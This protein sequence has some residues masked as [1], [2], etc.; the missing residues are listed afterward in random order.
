MLTL[1]RQLLRSK[2]F[3]GLIFG[4]V[5][6]GMAVW[7]IEDIFTGGTGAQVIKS[8]ERGITLAELN[9]AFEDNLQTE[10]LETGA[11]LTRKQGLDQGN[12]SE[13]IGQQSSSI[14][15]LGYA[16]EMRAD[17]SDAAVL[18]EIVSIPAFI[19]SSSNTFSKQ[20]LR[21]WLSRQSMTEREFEEDVRDTLTQNSLFGAIG[22]GVR[23]PLALTRVQAAVLSEERRFSWFT[24][25][26]GI[27]DPIVPP[28]DEEVQS[29]FNTN[30]DRYQTPERRQF[31]I[32]SISP[33]DFIDRAIVTDEQIQRRYEANLETRFTGEGERVVT[34]AAFNTK[35]SADTAFATLSVGG[36]IDNVDGL[37]AIDQPQLS[38]EDVP[39][40]TVGPQ[41]VLAD[42]MFARG[43]QE[44][45]M[46]GPY[47]VEGNWVIYRI[48]EIITGEV[49][50]LNEDIRAELYDELALDQGRE[51][52]RD[53][54]A[55]MNDLL[56]FGDTAEV[57]A[58]KLGVPL[59]RFDPIDQRGRTAEGTQEDVLMSKYAKGVAEGFSSLFEGQTG[60]RYDESDLIYLVT[61]EQVVPSQIPELD[62]VKDQIEAQ[63]ISER[64]NLAFDSAAQAIKTRLD[65]GEAT[66]ADEAALAGAVIEQTNNPVTRLDT[67]E[68]QGRLSGPAYQSLFEARAGD[69][70]MAQGL[71]AD[72]RIIAQLE[73]IS[74]TDPSE[75]DL[76]SES[77]LALRNQIISVIQNDILSAYDQSVGNDYGATID[78][79]P[80][81]GLQASIRND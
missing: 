7:G 42:L 18:D 11:R 60:A 68:I 3:G 41:Q 61:L 34:R 37:I 79:G 23:A 52:Y 28:T 31:A 12:F 66:L 80:I 67:L 63:I 25:D 24:V 49:E 50:P 26:Q 6:L 62:T 51:F 81:A 48:E 10:R 9:E 59:L 78:E 74:V 16:R 70:I 15:I 38:R 64:T 2:I 30:I 14:T 35:E 65:S 53:A 44:S 73:T 54:A 76:T 19:N 43:V 40:L 71:Q 32:V 56:L 21:S 4:I 20:L 58:E 57:M 77:S 33:E 69:V 46:F 13:V 36:S 22:A 45:R 47:T 27:I 75:I 5:I 1:M 8:G 55:E 39:D 72:Q 17:A 29:Y